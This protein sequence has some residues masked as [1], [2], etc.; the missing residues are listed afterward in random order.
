M[1]TAAG[2]ESMKMTSKERVDR[3]LR[4][5]DVDRPPFTFWYHFRLATLPGDRHAAA[6]LDFH[7]RLRTDL[8]KVMSDFPY[9]KPAGA[10]HQ[11]QVDKN[12]FPEQVRS[13]E[14]IRDG[15][16]GQ[17]PFV[18]TLFNPWRQAEKL[19]SPAE[20]K[21]LM[22]ARPQVLL[23]AL[24]AIT[25]SQMQHV[26]RALALGASGVFLAIANAQ[27]GLLTP[28]EYAK[29]SAPFD[30]MILEAASEAPLNILHLHGDKV[31]LDEFFN[32]WPAAVINYSMHDTKL[33]MA[34]VR[35]RFSG[36]L[37]GGLDEVNF[38]RL[39][40][41]EMRE[42]SRTARTAAGKRF[43]LAPGCSVPDDTTDEELLRLVSVLGA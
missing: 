23:D 42:Q 19:S 39:T 9:P 22:A 34:E 26:K 28:E 15:L 27:E 24:E 14:I 2:G 25:K 18:E 41:D 33:S 13:L 3:V 1:G 35:A 36:V 38:R 10:W 6:T 11:L 21:D 16:A 43:I 4:G 20:A 8:V 29:F 31:Y 40:A 7:R 30:K 32:G 37:M 12:P 5:D 17:A